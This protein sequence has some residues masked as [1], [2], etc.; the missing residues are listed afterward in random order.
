MKQKHAWEIGDKLFIRTVT[1]YFTGELVEQTEDSF[2]LKNA[3]WIADTGRFHAALANNA[4][5]EIEPYPGG[6]VVEI[7]RT[8][9]IDI[10][11]WKHELPLEV[12]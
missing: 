2:W 7:M 6:G 3:S 10:T 4:L 8:A 12:K 9:I 11:L 1:N 5:D